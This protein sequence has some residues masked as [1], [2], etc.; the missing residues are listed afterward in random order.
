[1]T[2]P[3]LVLSAFTANLRGALAG[4]AVV[5]SF[6]GPSGIGSAG[7]ATVAAAGC[8]W[9][10]R[11]VAAHRGLVGRVAQ[12]LRGP[13]LSGDRRRGR[14]ARWPAQGRRPRRAVRTRRRDRAGYRHLHL[15]G[16]H[17]VP[18]VGRSRHLGQRRG[19]AG[20]SVCRRARGRRLAAVVVGRRSPPKRSGRSAADAVGRG[21]PNRLVRHGR[22][23]SR[24]A[25]PRRLP[26]DRRRDRPDR[27]GTRRHD[28]RPD[29]G[30]GARSRRAANDAADSRAAAGPGADRRRA[31]GRPHRRPG[32]APGGARETGPCV[33]RRA[34]LDLGP[35]RTG[36][37]RHPSLR[38][39]NDRG[40]GAQRRIGPA[41]AG[42][43]ADGTPGDRDQPRPG[44]RRGGVERRSGRHQRQRN[45]RPVDATR[46]RRG[47]RQQFLRGPR[48]GRDSDHGSP[49]GRRQQQAGRSGHHHPPR[50]RRFELLGV[51][52]RAGAERQRRRR[53]HEPHPDRS[54]RR[55]LV[56][57]RRWRDHGRSGVRRGQR[58]PSRADRP[59]RW[60]RHL[61]GLDHGLPGGAAG[62]P[63]D[64]R[65]V[66][67][68]LPAGLLRGGRLGPGLRRLDPAAGRRPVLRRQL[69]VPQPVRVVDA[70]RVV[71][72]RR[73]RL[74]GHLRAG[75][76]LRRDGQR[77]H[78]GRGRG[79]GRGAGSRRREARSRHDQAHRNAARRPG[80]LVHQDRRRTGRRAGRRWSPVLHPVQVAGERLARQP[81]HAIPV[82]VLHRL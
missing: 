28:R 63:A 1:A 58:D 79:A 26:R 21:R 67:A 62:R 14:L 66:A 73:P 7:R 3:G 6:V 51:E 68:R 37:V 80:S 9:R 59:R 32:A 54:R 50:R 16:S 69:Q 11:H 53:P 12:P 72:R 20:R 40:A 55:V 82:P 18:G 52:P 10:R 33:V 23:R 4:L 27:T 47:G 49:T 17:L 25:A 61:P 39:G 34:E 74:G 35:G 13:S 5:E 56:P 41:G 71:V 8:P 31:R 43:L 60:R 22:R 24:F 70:G 29:A 36:Q 76:W 65:V 46:L 64:H 42:W 48:N 78:R 30:P 19:F 44:R 2:S 77:R 81:G 38:A 15:P 57:P 45:R 75:S